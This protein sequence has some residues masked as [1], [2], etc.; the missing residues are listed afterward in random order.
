[1]VSLE[2]GTMTLSPLDEM[3]LVREVADFKSHKKK[4]RRAW[5]GAPENTER[6]AKVVIS[7]KL[8]F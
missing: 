8:K 6:T 1:M 5:L 3:K 4:V 7:A 2:G